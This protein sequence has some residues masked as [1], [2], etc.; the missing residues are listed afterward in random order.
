MSGRLRFGIRSSMECHGK[1]SARLWE[2]SKSRPNKSSDT[3][4]KKSRLA[5]KRKT[6]GRRYQMTFNLFR[7]RPL[8]AAAIRD[9]QEERLLLEASRNSLAAKHLNPE[10]IGCPSH[11]LLLKLARHSISMDELKPWTSHLSSCGECF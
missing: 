10:R 5:C 11:D 4:S 9:E 6:P 2:Y 8:D 1:R 7:S 3:N